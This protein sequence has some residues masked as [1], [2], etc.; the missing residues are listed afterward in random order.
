[1]LEVRLLVLTMGA[2]YVPINE[3]I[4]TAMENRNERILVCNEHRKFRTAKTK[5]AIVLTQQ[6]GVR[7][8]LK[9]CEGMSGSREHQGDITLF[10]DVGTQL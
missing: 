1:M 10:I 4:T 8:D 6:D 9:D 7:N 2:A 3:Q 5:R